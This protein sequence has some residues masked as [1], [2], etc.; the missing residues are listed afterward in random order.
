MKFLSLGKICK[1]LALA[2]NSLQITI[3]M[4]LIKTAPYILL[5]YRRDKTHGRLAIVSRGA[6]SRW[7]G[8][9]RPAGRRAPGGKKPPRHPAPS[10]PA[11]P[12]PRRTAGLG[13]RRR[14]RTP[15]GSVP[16]R[17]VLTSARQATAAER[18]LRGADGERGRAGAGLSGE[19]AAA[20]TCAQPSLRR[21]LKTDIKAAGGEERGGQRRGGGAAPPDAGRSAHPPACSSGSSI[22]VP[23][24]GGEEGDAA[25]RGRGGRGPDPRWRAKIPAARLWHRGCLISILTFIPLFAPGP[26][27]AAVPSPLCAEGLSAARPA[28]LSAGKRHKAGGG[29]RAG[30]AQVGAS[31]GN[32]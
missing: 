2:S 20:A 4:T 3:I 29:L 24:A 14:P 22:S 19:Q 32:T 27:V 9:P 6:A 8:D 31:L 21:R 1:F 11:A 7:A 10:R 17:A 28:L 13:K 16:C 5:T 25:G 30:G 12:L 15:L 18:G 26:G 23:E